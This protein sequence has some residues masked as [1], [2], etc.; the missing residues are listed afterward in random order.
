M[1]ADCPECHHPMVVEYVDVGI[2]RV[3]HGIHCDFGHE[4]AATAVRYT[5]AA[6]P[7]LTVDDAKV[8]PN[9]G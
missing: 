2:G 8:A 5:P 3:W 4:L 9:F 1:Y 6:L 7:Q